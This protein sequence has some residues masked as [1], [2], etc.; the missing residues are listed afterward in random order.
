T[1]SDAELK[2]AESEYRIYVAKVPQASS[3]DY[4]I[5]HSSIIYV[6]GTDGRYLAEMPAGLPPKAMAATIEPYL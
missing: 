1:G 5:D 2:E 4:L 6:M 3:D